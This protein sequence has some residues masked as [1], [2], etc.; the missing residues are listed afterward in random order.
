MNILNNS[1]NNVIDNEKEIIFKR[2]SDAL[3]K[4]LLPEYH[5]LFETRI[6][7]NDL[8]ESLGIK[9]K[10]GK[11]ILE[12]NNPVVIASALNWYLKYI[13]GSHIGW[14]GDQINLSK[15]LHKVNIPVTMKSQFQYRYYLNYCTFSYSMPWWDWCRWEKEIDFMALNGINLALALVGQEAVW[16]IFM[17]ELGCTEKEVLEFLPGPAFSAWGWLNNLDGWGGPITQNWID[18]QRELQC[19]I[20][21]RMRALGITPMLQTFTGRVPK[22]LVRLFPEA[23]ISKLPGWYEYEGVYFLDPEDPLFKKLIRLFIETQTALYGNDHFFAGDLFHEIDSSDKTNDYMKNIYKNIQESMLEVDKDAKWVLQS[24]TIR[25]DGISI[26][27]KD[28]TIVLDMFCESESKWK[29]TEQFHGLPWIW[30]VINNF[31]G[32]T[33]MGGPINKIVE[34]FEKAKEEAP[35]DKLIGI[36]AVPEGIECNPIIYELLWEM[37]WR[38]EIKDVE[39]WIKKFAKRRYGLQ[40]DIINNAWIKLYKTVYSGPQGYAPLESVVCAV[41]SFNITKAGSNGFTELYYD[42]SILIEVIESLLSISGIL[43]NI[44]TYKYDIID[45]TRQFGANLLNHLYERIVCKY[46][47]KDLDGFKICSIVFMEI[48]QELDELLSC[49]KS[50]SLGFWLES[51]KKKAVDENDLKMLEWNARRQITLWSSPEIKEFHDYANKQ[52]S[53]LIRD[54]YLPR[55]KIFFNQCVQAIESEKEFDEK[56]FQNKIILNAIEW[57]KKNDVYEI[58][59]GYDPIL[60]AERFVN[61]YKKYVKNI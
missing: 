19:K 29:K 48:C 37:N 51:A 20:L 30:S 57:S 34:D 5:H 18:N 4:R 17:L 13:C 58:E 12:G 23:K 8:I 50:F 11:T 54:Y 7:G 40:S 41:P 22:A 28:H 2:E 59:S 52:W 1:V 36:G 53:G 9:N 49:N 47:E 10:N 43:K 32:R 27:D 39:D 33:G 35:K 3:I 21:E 16:Q 44:E 60:L 45:I 38:T 15:R 56:S 6:I 31:G 14:N 24:W 25:D 26:L 55:W 46:H 42:N 61:H